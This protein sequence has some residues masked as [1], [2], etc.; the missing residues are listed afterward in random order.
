MAKYTGIVDA[1]H[2]AEEVWRYLADL[3]SVRDGIRASRA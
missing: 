1:P 2:D 3:R